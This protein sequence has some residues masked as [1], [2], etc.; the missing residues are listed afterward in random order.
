MNVSCWLGGS[1]VMNLGEW[2]NYLILDYLGHSVEYRDTG[3]VYM[4]IGSEFHSRKV[5]QLLK[6]ADIVHIWGQGNGRPD[7]AP[8][9]PHPRVK[10]HAL[11]GPITARV[12]K[13][14]G[15]PLCDPGWLLPIV[16]PLECHISKEVLHIPHHSQRPGRPPWIDVM[17]RKEQVIPTI[18]RIVNA[19]KVMT[20]TLH[21]MI[22]CKAY[23]VPCELCSGE[24]NMPQKWDDVF[25]SDLVPRQHSTDAL[26]ESFPL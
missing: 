20:N 19:K 4:I 17:L 25:H 2:F 11:R 15:V 22:L 10:V 6:T 16:L 21:T 7:I 13:V 24:L 18:Q 5:N 23:G 12:S 1:V 26:L 3:E 9:L 14:T 8:M